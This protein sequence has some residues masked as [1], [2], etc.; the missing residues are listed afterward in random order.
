MKR[1]LE[2]PVWTLL[3]GGVC[4]ANAQTYD[5]ALRRNFWNAG[6]NING[7]LADSLSVSYASV[8]GN[9]ESGGFRDANSSTLQWGAGAE[10]ATIAHLEKFSLLGNF[11][12]KDT[13][14]YGACGSMSGR[15]GYYPIEAY[16][17][18][19]GRKTRQ[20]YSMRGGVAVP[21]SGGWS[22]GGSFDIEAQNY[23]K[24]KDLRH[25]NYLLDLTV[26]PSLRWQSGDFSIGASY[27]LSKNSETVTAEE[28]GITS[29]V[30]Y[31]F[32][33]KGLLYG[34]YDQWDNSNI[35]LKESGISGLPIKEITNGGALQATWR[36]L[37]VDLQV[38]GHHGQ[39]GEKQKIYNNFR[40]WEARG[41]VGYRIENHYLRGRWNFRTQD[42]LEN[43]L[44]NVTE[45]G[46]TT[47]VNYG[48]NKILTRQRFTSGFE[49]EMLT[50][51]GGWWRAGV[52]WKETREVASASYP[53]IMTERRDILGA[54]G[55]FLLKFG[56]VDW[57]MGAEL[58]KGWVSEATR[59]SETTVTSESAPYRLSDYYTWLTEFERKAKGAVSLALRYNFKLGIYIDASVRV[60]SGFRKNVSAY[61]GGARC[62]ETLSVGYNF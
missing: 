10:A 2:I 52:E 33:D 15:A 53:Y 43:I 34:V 24:R 5:I 8:G 28:L 29:G 19:P 31:A 1:F 47:T 42:N 54:Y 45:N 50:R 13:E 16:E 22:I 49:W 36:E 20:V 35:H 14:Y 11:S 3:L 26:A 55:C 39:S 30:Y 37:Y 32:L 25:T 12:F 17:F 60:V 48:S 62:T 18:T 40:G 4:A 44:E 23:T 21:L 27:I 6:Q 57:R 59:L 58:S 51:G 7:L 41:N 61:F 9:F 38:S 46:V 56:P